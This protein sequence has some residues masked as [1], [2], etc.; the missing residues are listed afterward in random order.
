MRF[1]IGIERSRRRAVPL[2]Y[3]GD[4]STGRYISIGRDG[5][6]L[7]LMDD[8]CDGYTDTYGSVVGD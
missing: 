6:L 5:T 1:S 3:L 2:L 7:R 4:D 8:V